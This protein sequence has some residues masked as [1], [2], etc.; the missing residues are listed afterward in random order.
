MTPLILLLALI[1][2]L[3]KAAWVDREEMVGR[4]D[5]RLKLEAIYT[6]YRLFAKKAN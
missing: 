3:C 4:G 2:T 6:D 5:F 1:M